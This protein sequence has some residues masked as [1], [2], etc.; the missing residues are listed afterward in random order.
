MLNFVFISPH[1][2]SNYYLFCRAL[3]Q[4]GVNVLGIA[5]THYDNLSPELKDSLSDYYQVPSLE[6]GDAVLRAV[7]W[8]THKWGKIDWLESNN[9]Y[10]LMQDAW[11]RTMFHIDT[12]P[13]LKDMEKFKRKSQMKLL[14]HEAGVKT[15]P[16]EVVTTRE[17][18]FEFANKYGYP[19][20]I[21]P[22]IG[23]GAQGIY[24]IYNQDDL[25]RFFDKKPYD[26][27]IMEVLVKGEVCSYDA[28]LDSKGTPLYE[29]GNIT[30]TSLVDVVNDRLDSAF[31]LLPKPADDVLEAG[32]NTV[33]A[34]DV[35]N[36]MIHFE[37]FRLM[38]DQEGLGKKGDIL[39]LEVNMRPSGGISPDMMNFAGSIDIY[40]LWA[41]MVCHDRV[42]LQD[43]R[44][45]FVCPFVGL[46]D[47]QAYKLSHSDIME[48]YGHRIVKQGR[49]PDAMSGAMGNYYYIAKCLD[50]EE[51]DA[52][53]AA[54]SERV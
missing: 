11:L 19:L 39:G 1:F 29:T 4:N 6:D 15:A 51:A 18:G 28:I 20:I 43:E 50:R 52:F 13:M 16:G 53:I 10:W 24:K 25:N 26:P 40:R 45:T 31:M 32:R 7:A 17:K 21:K 36:R 47:N 27:Y 54:V 5:D 14:Y 12:G 48:R 9:E 41:D 49:V 35:K 42:W 8:F 23:V 30:V 38:E 22:D 34:F 3:K 37:F 46:R 2:P 44:S 33:K